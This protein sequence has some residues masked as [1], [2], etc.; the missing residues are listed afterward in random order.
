MRT[1]RKSTN[2]R[3][4]PSSQEFDFLYLL[5][6]VTQ[7][8]ARSKMLAEYEIKFGVT[9]KTAKER[10]EQIDLDM[11]GNVILQT[12]IFIPRKAKV[13]EDRLKKKWNRRLNPRNTGPS[14]GRTEWRRV[15]WLE[16][17]FILTDYWLIRNRKVINYLKL[18]ILIIAAFAAYLY[19]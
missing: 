12:W 7:K 5:E 10:T 8:T 9:N 6:R 19:S 16:Y 15:T 2:R 13:Y 14:A 1:K 18:I 11:P 4:K 17:T 3:K